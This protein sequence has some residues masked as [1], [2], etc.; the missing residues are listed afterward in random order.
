[1]RRN[2]PPVHDRLLELKRAR[3]VPLILQREH[4]ECGL[5]CVAMVAGWFGHH[6]PLNVLRARLPP[7]SRGATL[8][9][10]LR[11]AAELNMSGRPLRLEFPDLRRLALPAILHWRMQHFVV[12]TRLNSRNAT[13]HDPA[14]GKRRVC[15][16]ELNAGFTGVA[17]ELHEAKGFV[18]RDRRDSLSFLSFLASCRR[19]GRYLALMLLLLVTVQVLALVPP[20]ATQL[21]IDEVVLGQDV[22]WLYRALGGLALVLLITLLLD[23]MRRWIAL[24]A[25]SVLAADSTFNVVRHLYNLPAQFLKNR[26]L[27]DLM[28]RLESLVP[29]RKAITETAVEAIVQVAV[30][31]ATLGIMLF[32]SPWLTLVSA[33][34]L[35]LS[36][37]LITS[38]LPAMRRL[39]E[40]TL[41]HKALGDSSLLETIRACDSTLA[42]GLAPLRLAQ[43]QNHFVAAMNTRVQQSKLS[44]WHGFGT[45]FIGGAEQVLFL[46]V[47]ITQLVDKQLTLGVLFAFMTLRNRLGAAGMSLL[48]VLQEMFML[49]MHV[50]RLSDIVL[51]EPLP[52]VQRG[53]LCRPVA[54]SLQAKNLC[55][56][57]AGGPIVLQD[58]C[59]VIQPGESVVIAGPSGCGKTT[60]LKLLSAQVSPVAGDILIDGRELAL[61]NR[62]HLCR[63][64]S[65]VLQDDALF[66]GSIVEN[67]SAFD[68]EP[69]LD[70]VR[71][72]AEGAQIWQDIRHMP[73]SFNTLVGDMGSSLSGGQRQR[74]LLARALYREPRILFLDEAT[75]HLDVA[76]E[77]RVLDHLESLGITIVSVAHRPDVLRRASRTIEL[78]PV[79]EH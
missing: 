74:I 4:A 20:V 26:H 25:G 72:A 17:M 24:Y 49:K 1:M 27:G 76:T 39:G 69:D 43:W 15:M 42:L 37:I 55:F 64:F 9:D 53:A 71:C 79:S 36:A 33:V 13:I 29:V 21:L 75:S 58:F 5:A 16:K 14:C 34:G 22:E 61:W 12:L 54:G 44:I 47:G 45:G 65:T 51:A 62:H 52:P 48:G 40:Q 41:V 30:L 68:P 19:L 18:R 31:L 77:A 50:D 38:I 46:G 67:I 59:G 57:Y 78:T 7:S 2:L 73:M 11:T 3:R 28:S 8:N 66:K 35:A 6:V 60:L 23:A 63:Q 10:L 32:Y 56:R 70:R